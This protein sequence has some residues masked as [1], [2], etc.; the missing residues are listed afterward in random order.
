MARKSIKSS[1]VNH[2]T[3]GQLTLIDLVIIPIIAVVL[4]TIAIVFLQSST[5]SLLSKVSLQPLQDSCNFALDNMYSTYYVHSSYE[6]G[7]LKSNHPS[8]YAA[9]ISSSFLNL[10]ASCGSNCNLGYSFVPNSLLNTSNSLYVSFI[11]YFSSFAISDFNLNTGANIPT[12]NAI[13]MQVFLNHVPPLNYT[14]LTTC[15][16]TVYNPADPSHPYTIYGVIR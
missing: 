5:A 2:K 4:S 9:A 12:L 11:N 6:L 3:K 13:N 14:P 10:N 16:M 15:S 7:Y 8:Q 1:D